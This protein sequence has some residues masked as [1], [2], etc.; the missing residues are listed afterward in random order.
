MV[1]F[2]TRVAAA[3]DRDVELRQ[4]V[5]TLAR[6]EGVAIVAWVVSE[7]LRGELGTDATTRS[8]VA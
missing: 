3:G 6:I 5:Y 4:P 2:W 8:D 7:W 1:D